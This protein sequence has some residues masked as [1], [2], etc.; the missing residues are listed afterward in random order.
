MAAQQQFY[1][2]APTLCSGTD[3]MDV[4]T[5]NTTSDETPTDTA[6]F[7]LTNPRD[8][9]DRRVSIRWQG[10]KYHKGTFRNFNDTSGKHL[11]VY[12]DGDRRYYH[13]ADKI[14]KVDGD[15][16]GVTYKP[17]TSGDE[18]PPP[19]D[20]ASPSV[21]RKAGG[22]GVAVDTVR[23]APEVVDEPSRGEGGGGGRPAPASTSQVK[24]APD[25]EPGGESGP[26]REAELRAAPRHPREYDIPKIGTPTPPPVT[27][28][29]FATIDY[30]SVAQ[31]RRDAEVDARFTVRI[32]QADLDRI[33]AF[34]SEYT[35]L[36]TGGD[37]WGTWLSA[38]LSR[39]RAPLPPGH[40]TNM[41]TCTPT[42]P[43]AH[44]HKLQVSGS[45]TATAS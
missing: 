24:T 45:P 14:F 30:A 2:G 39:G 42:H 34:T 18:A 35:S 8:L 31:Q 36:E 13:M 6:P 5:E 9:I 1:F 29:A 12:D 27:H 40:P 19:D 23:L 33:K 3:T 38:C 22:G 41:P 15:P 11:V 44:A 26:A 20:R 25:T 28:P 37:L 21:N 7:W 17:W 43:S 32:S 4:E 16:S 10:N